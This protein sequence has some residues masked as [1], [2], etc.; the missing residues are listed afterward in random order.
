MDYTGSYGSLTKNN[1][2]Q[3]IFFSDL[4]QINGGDVCKL[5]DRNLLHDYM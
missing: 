3:A 2:H 5:N 1:E 4:L